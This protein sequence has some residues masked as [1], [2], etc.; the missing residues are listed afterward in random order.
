MLVWSSA[1]QTVEKMFSLDAD[2][3]EGAPPGADIPH[4]AW[5]TPLEKYDLASP[6]LVADTTSAG[7]SANPDGS[8]KSLPAANT[9][10][11]PLDQ[12]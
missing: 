11:D 4:L 3:S 1:T 9:Q 7:S 10:M 5:P 8:T 2:T 12:A 6:R